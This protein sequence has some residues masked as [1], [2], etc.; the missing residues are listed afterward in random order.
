MKSIAVK[1]KL[2][3]EI[4]ALYALLRDNGWYSGPQTLQEQ[5]PIAE[6][7]ST[8]QA[9]TVAIKEDETAETKQPETKDSDLEESL[10]RSE[11]ESVESSS[12]SGE[13]QGSPSPWSINRGLRKSGQ[14]PWVLEHVSFLTMLRK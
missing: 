6:V 14:Q 10:T 3:E 7:R 1:A 11:Q 9:A 4:D 8:I 5:K 13:A 2:Q 12:E